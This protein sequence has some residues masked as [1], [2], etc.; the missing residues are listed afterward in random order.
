MLLARKKGEAENVE[1]K[2]NVDIS[3][4]W[5]PGPAANL[6]FHIDLSQILPRIVEDFNFEEERKEEAAGEHSGE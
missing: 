6:D 4:E 1:L 5:G 2:D 3:K